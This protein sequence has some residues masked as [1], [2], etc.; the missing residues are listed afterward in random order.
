MEA[1]M[2]LAEQLV[3]QYH[4]DAGAEEAKRIFNNVFKNEI[5]PDEPDA[6]VLC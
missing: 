1:K 6:H 4:G 5:F 3:R 2:A